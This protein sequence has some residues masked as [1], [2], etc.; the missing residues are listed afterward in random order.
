MSEHIREL[1]ME[2]RPSKMLPGEIGVFAT[3]S[4]PKGTSVTHDD[5]NSEKLTILPME[6]FGTL[7]KQLQDKIRHFSVQREEGY[8]VPKGI[9][10]NELSVSWY[11]NH[12]CEGNLGFDAHGD[13]V[14]RRDIEVGEELTYDYGLIES[15]DYKMECTCGSSRCRHTITGVDYQNPQFRKENAEYLYPDLR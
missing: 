9:D 7:S 12:S 14:A 4:I 15:G 5:E 8:L 10:Y 3:V 2:L 6:Q 13:Y 11:F 1:L